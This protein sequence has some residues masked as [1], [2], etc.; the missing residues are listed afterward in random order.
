M[1]KADPHFMARALAPLPYGVVLVS[2]TNGKTTTT[3]MVVELLRGQGLKV[4][5]NPTGS[6][7]TRGVVAALLG[8]MPLNGRLDADV[9]VLELDE[10]HATHFV[11][12]VKPRAAL[13]LNVMRDQLDRFG[14]IDYT[15]S[16]LHKVARAT[17]GTVRAW[18]PPVSV[19]IC[20]LM[21]EALRSAPSCVAFFFPT[22]SCTTPSTAAP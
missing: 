11:R 15:A 3:R 1:E 12:T 10:A 20:A 22:T 4:F 21:C 8:A 6:N 19:L 9:A 16:L 18:L 14:E 2:G 5:T 7:F 13:L 17:T